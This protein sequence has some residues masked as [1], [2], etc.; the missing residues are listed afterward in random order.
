MIEKTSRVTQNIPPPLRGASVHKGMTGIGPVVKPGQT[1]DSFER[2]L[3]AYA[4]RSCE[5]ALKKE[6]STTAES[7]HPAVVIP[8]V[9]PDIKENIRQ[10]DMSLAPPVG[11]P[12]KPDHA[13]Y[14]NMLTPF[15]P[16]K[17]KEETGGEKGKKADDPSPV[18]E[19]H[20]LGFAIA[21]AGILGGV[22]LWG[23]I[24]L[25]KAVFS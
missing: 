16:E 24:E 7:P 13:S 10:I 23:A 18:I 5:Y 3:F 1:P 4:L 20:I 25:I 15:T 14:V 6:H 17:K 22:F 11:D 2:G 9:L 19:R 12:A 21:I 8:V